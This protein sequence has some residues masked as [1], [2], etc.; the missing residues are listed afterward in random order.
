MNEIHALRELRPEAPPAKLDALRMAARDRFLTGLGSKRAPQRWRLPVLAGGL[1]AAAAGGAAAALVLT[2]GPVATPAQGT[3][4]H[5]GTVVTAAWTVREDANGTVRVYLRQYANP[6][7]LQR[8]LRADGINAIVR[9]IPHTVRT[10]VGPGSRPQQAKAKSSGAARVAL[11]T[12][13]YADT[14]TAPAAVQHAVLTIVQQAAPT[15]FIVHPGAMPQGSV[16]FL[17]FMASG[18][19]GAA[20]VTSWA[21]KPVVLRSSAVPACMPVRSVRKPAR[22]PATAPKVKPAQTP[23]PKAP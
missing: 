6:A 21:M 7:G 1:T 19:S 13:V 22:A 23:A 14:D 5:I 9:P 15:Y 18:P 4:R 3:G 20:G 11:P 12:C 8:T 10:V 16:L 2:G 17:P